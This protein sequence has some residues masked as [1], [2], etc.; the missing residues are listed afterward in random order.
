MKGDQ[1]F[2][3]PLVAFD[4]S[5]HSFYILDIID[6]MKPFIPKISILHVHNSK[7][8]YLNDRFR[9]PAIFNNLKDRYPSEKNGGIS[10]ELKDNADKNTNLIIL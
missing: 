9:G 2:D 4:N 1:I 3:N 7:K 8:L 5:Q 10:V 6:S